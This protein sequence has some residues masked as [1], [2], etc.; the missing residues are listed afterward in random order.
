MTEQQTPKQN[1][2]FRRMSPETQRR[3]ASL[4]G[5]AAHSVGCAHEFNHDEAVAAGSKG[6]KAAHARGTAHEWTTEEASKVGKLGG[7][8]TAKKRRP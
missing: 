7:M 2:G 8:A 5:K 1:R 6:G 4:G 3:I